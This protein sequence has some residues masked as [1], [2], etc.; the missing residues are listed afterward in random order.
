MRFTASLVLL[1]AACSR[2]VWNEDPFTPDAAPATEIIIAGRE[3]TYVLRGPSYYL[4]TS[5]RAALW[6]RETVDDVAWRYRSLFGD[7][8]PLIAVGLDSAGGIAAW[9]RWRGVPLAVVP[10][11]PAGAARNEGHRTERAERDSATARLL[12]RPMLAATAAEAWLRA[13]AMDAS[14][15]TDSQPGGPESAIGT[16]SAMPAWFEAAALRLLASPGAADRANAEVRAESKGVVPLATLFAVQW[17]A[18]PNAGDIAGVGRAM[19]DSEGGMMSARVERP[20]PPRDRAGVPGVAPL[21]ISQA[22]SVLAFI[23]E[24]DPLLVARLADQLPRGRSV[25]D[26]LAMSTGLPRDV[27]ALEAEWTKWVKRT[28]RRT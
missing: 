8:P 15:A 5:Q 1:L 17:Q 28:A 19:S 14:R 27:A 23:R 24:R 26:L 10:A 13:R 16:V 18:R 3:T 25:V 12:A 2:F 11:L 9:A 4:L 22:T 7:A 6:S 21:F 20:R